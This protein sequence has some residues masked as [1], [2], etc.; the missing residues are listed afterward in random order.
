MFT[1]I[2]EI[3]SYFN[4]KHIFCECNK[5]DFVDD[6]RYKEFVFNSDDDDDIFS[7]FDEKKRRME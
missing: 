4:M 6:N 7:D 5:K 1:R 3:K 2:F